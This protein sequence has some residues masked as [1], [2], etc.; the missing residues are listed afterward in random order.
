[1]LVL[2]IVLVLSLVPG[3]VLVQRQVFVQALVPALVLVTV[4]AVGALLDRLLVVR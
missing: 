2:V 1:M 3:L 4:T